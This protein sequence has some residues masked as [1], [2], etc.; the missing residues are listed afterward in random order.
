[1]AA[2]AIPSDAQ[3]NRPAPVNLT[4]YLRE[5][6]LDRG[7]GVEVSYLR[8]D[9]GQRRGLIALHSASVLAARCLAEMR[10]NDRALSP[11]TRGMVIKIDRHRI[12]G[13]APLSLLL[14]LHREAE[15]ITARPASANASKSADI[16]N[17]SMADSSLNPMSRTIAGS[18]C[19]QGLRIV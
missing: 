17:T 14:V 13:P 8:Q 9:I 5:T 4:L 7:K 10:V 19:I 16:F 6:I 1:M 11:S 3:T 2:P 12:G 18:Q 15:R